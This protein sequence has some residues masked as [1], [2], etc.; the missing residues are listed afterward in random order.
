[1]LGSVRKWSNRKLWITHDVTGIY[2]RIES[3]CFIPE[4]KWNLGPTSKHI[5]DFP[6]NMVH[7]EAVPTGINWFDENKWGSHFLRWPTLLSTVWVISQGCLRRR[8]DDSTLAFPPHMQD[9][10][11]IDGVKPKHI[12]IHT[13]VCVYSMYI[14]II[15]CTYNKCVYIYICIYNIRIIYMIYVISIPSFSNAHV[16]HLQVL[17]VIL[18]VRSGKSEVYDYGISYDYIRYL[19]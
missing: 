13:Q 8:G 19:V 1:M 3:Y 9:K 2:C 4:T 16:A 14:Q 6:V 5:Q 11:M 15:L 12:Y 10:L 7:C 17:Q 18:Q